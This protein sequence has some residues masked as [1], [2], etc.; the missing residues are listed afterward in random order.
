MFFLGVES[1]KIIEDHY[2]QEALV[3]VLK[4]IYLLKPRIKLK[5][6]C[7]RLGQSNVGCLNC[8]QLVGKD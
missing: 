6:S 1:Y 2:N 3:K 7:K 4:I 5:V 8:L